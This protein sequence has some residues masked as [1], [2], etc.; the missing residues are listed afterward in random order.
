M[1]RVQYLLPLSHQGVIHGYLWMEDPVEFPVEEVAIQGQV[2]KCRWVDPNPGRV[3]VGSTPSVGF[4]AA[5]LPTSDWNTD[6]QC[7]K[8]LQG[9][10]SFTTDLPQ[11]IWRVTTSGMRT[12]PSERQ[13][14]SLW[15]RFLTGVD[16]NPIVSGVPS[17][18]GTP[19]GPTVEIPVA[20]EFFDEVG[21]TFID[22]D[23]YASVYPDLAA[24]VPYPKFVTVESLTDMGPI[25][26]YLIHAADLSSQVPR[27]IRFVRVAV[28][29]LTES[30]FSFRL[31]VSGD[32]STAHA[33]LVL[34]KL[35]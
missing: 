11:G 31:S 24:E 10:I 18:G 14:L 26:P 35:P 25:T 6:D 32:A 7:P 21:I 13:H 17:M 4:G 3:E 29:P 5:V 8:Y 33:T 19:T 12:D 15:S 28:D 1:S 30:S 2:I 22:F 23:W 34:T 9:F 27:I 20:A 16:F